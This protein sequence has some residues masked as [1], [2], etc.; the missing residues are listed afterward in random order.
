M[1]TDA[2]VCVCLCVCSL[3]DGSRH[4]PSALCIGQVPLT[5]ALDHASVSRFSFCNAATSLLFNASSNA[6]GRSA[7][8]STAAGTAAAHKSEQSALIDEALA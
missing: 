7:A 2:C 3:G 5:S 1:A 6:I 8:A 4:S